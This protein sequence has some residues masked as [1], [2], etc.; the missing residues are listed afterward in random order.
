MKDDM[1][2]ELPTEPENYGGEEEEF[3]NQGQFK[4]TSPLVLNLNFDVQRIEEA[5]FN[6]LTLNNLD[7][8]LLK[9]ELAD[10]NMYLKNIHKGFGKV[11]STRS[12]I[13]LVGAGLAVHKHRRQV[14]KD[15]KAGQGETLQWDAQGNLIT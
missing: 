2:I 4:D 8:A 7:K 1:D 13:A 15:L 12:L 6:H 5:D 11:T 14:L 3:Q 9:A 10:S